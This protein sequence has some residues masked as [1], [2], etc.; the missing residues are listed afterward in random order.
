M[1]RRRTRAQTLRSTLITF[2]V[3]AILEIACRH[4]LAARDTVA[5][6]LAGGGEASRIEVGLAVGF[7]ILR[8]LVWLILPGLVARDA[9]MALLDRSA[10]PA[11]NAG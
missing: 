6:L 4:L 9:V 8:L 1:K 7:V 5:V 11:R 3:A 10:P 2:A